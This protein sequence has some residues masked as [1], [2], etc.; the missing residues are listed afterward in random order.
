MLKIKQHFHV[1]FVCTII[2]S[3][4]YILFSF[5]LFISFMINHQ[6]FNIFKIY[7]FRTNRERLYSQSYN[8]LLSKIIHLLV[9]TCN[10]FYSLICT[11]RLPI[12]ATLPLIIYTYIV[13]GFVVLYFFC[14]LFQQSRA[15][16]C[17][18]SFGMLLY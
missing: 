16:Y 15:N 17:E 4:K 2:D 8:Q 14:L 7:L 6:K 12:I 3:F 10:Q 1:F 18:Y 11:I 9:I 5:Y 13:Y